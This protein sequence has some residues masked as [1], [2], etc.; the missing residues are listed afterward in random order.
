MNNYTRGYKDAINEAVRLIELTGPSRIDKDN[1]TDFL[2]RL[3]PLE[4]D[5]T[6]QVEKVFGKKGESLPT[7]AD[8]L[9][10]WR[11]Y[12]EDQNLITECLKERLENIEIFL[13]REF[14]WEPYDSD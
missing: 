7:K 10:E 5:N 3:V 1:L 2:K 4:V 9:E 8:M 11:E 6:E 12:M 13:E 14:G